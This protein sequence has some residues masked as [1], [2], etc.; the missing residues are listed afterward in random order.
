MTEKEHKIINEIKRLQAL[1]F[2]EG[3]RLTDE[4]AYNAYMKVR[5][6]EILFDNIKEFTTMHKNNQLVHRNKPINKR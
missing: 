2:I 3:V 6:H 5:H 1:V 4:E